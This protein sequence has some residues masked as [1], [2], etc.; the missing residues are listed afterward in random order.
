MSWPRSQYNPAFSPPSCHN[1]PWCIAIQSLLLAFLSHNTSS[2]LRYNCLSSTPFNHNTQP[3]HT[4]PANLQY[5]DCIATQNPSHLQYNWAVAQP[6][7]HNNNFFFFIILSPFFPATGKILKKYLYLYFFFFHFPPSNKF[8]KIKFSPF[9][10][11]LHH[12]KP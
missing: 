5:N 9:S 2:V 3:A 4:S 10:S 11:I 1:T 7:L 6:I 12:I 8:I